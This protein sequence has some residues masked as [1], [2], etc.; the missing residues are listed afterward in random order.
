MT[1]SQYPSCG[2]CN[3]E[4]SGDGAIRADD[5]SYSA[6]DETDVD[7]FLL[8]VNCNNKAGPPM[9]CPVKQSNR[10]SGNSGGSLTCADSE[11]SQAAREPCSGEESPLGMSLRDAVEDSVALEMNATSSVCEVNDEVREEEDFESHIDATLRTD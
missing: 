11:M 3:I 8:D 10:L 1:E 4:G 7:Q 5:K 6:T 2:D 9:S